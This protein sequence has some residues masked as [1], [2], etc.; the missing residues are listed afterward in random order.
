MQSVIQK[1]SY[2]SVKVFWL[3]K[4]LLETNILNA[5]NALVNNHHE[6]KKVILFGSIAE[7]RGLPSS[8]VDILIIVSKSKCRFID[9][10]LDFQKFFDDVG[11]RVDLFVYT[12]EEIM[13]NNIPLVN[14]ALKT[15]KILFVK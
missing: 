15:G 8:D 9:R 14:T 11:L 12:E 4:G 2:N 10:A 7:N 3:D 5:V 13:K 6:V 1:R